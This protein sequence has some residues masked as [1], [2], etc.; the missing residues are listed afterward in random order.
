MNL[1]LLRTAMDACARSSP[2]VSLSLIRIKWS[3]ICA[4]RSSVVSRVEHREGV[5]S[6]SG[7]ATLTRLL[8]LAA[9][10]SGTRDLERSRL[11]QAHQTPH[12]QELRGM[13][14]HP[15]VKVLHE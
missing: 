10:G 8:E 11:L 9:A 14:H 2:G 12:F 6:A 4:N 3:R 1:V 5:R 13:A 7:S 15:H